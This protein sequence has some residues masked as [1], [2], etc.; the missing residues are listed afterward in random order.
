MFFDSHCHL[1]FEAFEQDRDMIIKE[2]AKNGL[3]AV[4]V[5]SCVENSVQAQ[6]LAHLY[7]HL[8]AAIGIHPLHSLGFS[9]IKDV[10]E[11]KNIN[12]PQSI[13][14]LAELVD[15][16]RV[17]AIGEC[18]LDFSYFTAISDLS[19]IGQSQ[20]IQ[21]QKLI[22]QQQIR[23]AQIS[24]KPLILHL[25]DVYQLALEILQKED[26]KTTALFHFFKG[27]L[28]DT[29][30]ILKNPNYFFSFSGVITYNNK[31]NEVIKI[32]PLDRILIETDSPYATPKPVVDKRNT[33]L[34]ISYIAG[35]IAEI[36]QLSLEEVQ[37]ITFENSCRFFKIKT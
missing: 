8:W 3:Q 11:T 20:F 4:V 17:V 14:K 22:F 33:P 31:L 18:G 15:D 28:A 9:L 30:A 36:K 12:Y 25:R 6:N 19:D 2:L 26:Y 35:K 10:L 32:I 7:P 5:G 24:N 37:K 13:N 1:Q 16:P 21:Q 29:L 27:N 34:N 23:L